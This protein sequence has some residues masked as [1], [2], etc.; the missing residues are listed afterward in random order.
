MSNAVEDIE[1]VLL[2]EDE[3]DL[4]QV[5]LREL[6]AA[7]YR[8][9]HAIDG[10]K[11]LEMHERYQPDVVVLDWMLPRLNG[12]EVLRRLRQK[13]ATPVLMLTARGEETDR[14]LGLELGADDYLTKPFSLRELVA[15]VR[16]LLRRSE[17]IRKTLKADRQ[18]VSEKLRI[19]TLE[20]DP[21]THQVTLDG[22]LLDLSPTEF[23]LLQLLMR[24]PGRAFSRSYL[25]E[26]LW[27]G[28]Y[29][30]GDRSV[31]NV[32]LRLRKKLGA[33]GS[34]IETVWGIGYRLRS[35]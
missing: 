2:V 4:A 22:V 3:A 14:V 13:S 24:S 7:G 8:T 9:Y 11:A 17:L 15:R 23:E 20:L 5:V 27:S 10:I 30:G 18:Q 12:L 26:T 6:A 31:D 28:T 1:T 21:Q 33:V 35:E 32:V 29:V 25:I 19:K 16:A 34:V